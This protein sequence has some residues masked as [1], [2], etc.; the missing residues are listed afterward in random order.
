MTYSTAGSRHYSEGLTS[1]IRS[2]VLS[3][4][5]EIALILWN[6]KVL[7]C[8]YNSP[9]PVP[10]LS[11]ID[12]VH[13]RFPHPTSQKSILMLSSHLCLGLSNGHYSEVMCLITIYWYYRYSKGIANL[14]FKSSTCWFV[15]SPTFLRGLQPPSSGW[16][17]I[18]PKL[19]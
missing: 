12:P 17:Q 11:Q 14:R 9:P 18:S 10:I 1:W 7:Y 13:A 19:R 15:Q 4:G 2:H 8:I 3:A 6:P 5:Q 16:Q